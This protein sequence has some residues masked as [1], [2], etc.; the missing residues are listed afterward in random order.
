MPGGQKT[1]NSSKAGR[2]KKKC[3]RYKAE[4]RHE[5]NKKKKQVRHQKHMEYFA[6]RCERKTKGGE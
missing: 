6:R 3:E 5:K 2:D 4:G 1:G